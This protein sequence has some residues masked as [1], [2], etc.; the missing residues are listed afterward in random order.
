MANEETTINIAPLRPNQFKLAEHGYRRFSAVVKSA[1]KDLIEDPAL[2][3]NVAAKIN[4]GDEVRILAEDMSWVAYA[5]CLHSVGSQIKL[6]ILS[7]YDLDS[8]TDDDGDLPD[9]PYIAKQRG[10]LK[11]CIQDTKTGQYVR[12]GIATKAEAVKEIDELIKIMSR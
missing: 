1:D 11:W 12:E 2:W 9:A 5:I 7:G 8:V 4:I 10:Q 6:K 3:V